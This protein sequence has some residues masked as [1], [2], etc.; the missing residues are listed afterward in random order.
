MV[1]LCTEKLMQLADGPF[2]PLAQQAHAA[3]VTRDAATLCTIARDLR[4]KA[5]QKDSIE[6]DAAT[7]LVLMGDVIDQCSGTHF[8]GEAT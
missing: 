1:R 2:A 3:I 6:A 5:P 7:C 4:E 8:S